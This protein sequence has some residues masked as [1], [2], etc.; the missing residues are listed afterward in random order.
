MPTHPATSPELQ[1]RWGIGTSESP[2]PCSKIF[3]RSMGHLGWNFAVLRTSCA[4]AFQLIPYPARCPTR[5]LAAI[6]LTHTG[7]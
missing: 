4:S 2:S 6:V 1:G 3:G 5:N 7:Q